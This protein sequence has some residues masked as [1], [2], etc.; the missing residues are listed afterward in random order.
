MAG[1]SEVPLVLELDLAP[2]SPV[3]RR[4]VVARDLR[5][6]LDELDCHQLK[7]VV[8]WGL[9]STVVTRALKVMGSNLTWAMDVQSNRDQYQTGLKSPTG[10][11]RI[12]NPLNDMY[13]RLH[14]S[15]QCL[16]GRH[17]FLVKWVC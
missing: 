9:N 17:S 6:L 16:L 14:K 11:K 13:R 8:L 10:V 5:P 1:A 3:G 2:E 12:F 15:E 4:D 7:V